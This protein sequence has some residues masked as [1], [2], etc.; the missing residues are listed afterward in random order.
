MKDLTKILDRSRNTSSKW[1]NETAKLLISALFCLQC[2][3]KR[4]LT[5]LFL[6]GIFSTKKFSHSAARP[7][8]PASCAAYGTPRS[9]RG[10]TI[11]GGLCLLISTFT[12]PSFASVYE[13]TTPNGVTHFS[14]KPHQNAKTLKLQPITPAKSIS[15]RTPTQAKSNT[16]YQKPD[17]PNS[18]P[19]ILFPANKKTFQ[20][21]R[22]ITVKTSDISPWLEQNYRAEVYLDGKAACVI[23]ENE[24]T[25]NNLIR[26]THHLQVVLQKPS[27]KKQIKGQKVTIYVHLAKAK[28]HLVK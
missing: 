22:S 2:I 28:F 1:L 10:V 3:P 6:I 20:N 11:L 15:A 13:W 4:L 16:Q 19:G 25:I 8:D 12:T 27:D 23:K 14:D 26:G 24:C 9:S 21:Q 18:P 5:A 7:R 17:L